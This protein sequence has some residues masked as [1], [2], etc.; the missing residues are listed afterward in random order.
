MGFG[1]NDNI[2]KKD[3]LFNDNRV[4]SRTKQEKKCI[5][6]KM[7]TFQR[8][9][10]FSY[11][12]MVI[13]YPIFYGSH[14]LN[15][16]LPCLSAIQWPSLKIDIVSQSKMRYLFIW[17]KRRYKSTSQCS[18]LCVFVPVWWEREKTWDW[19][20]IASAQPHNILYRLTSQPY[21]DNGTTCKKKCIS[22]RTRLI[23]CE[24]HSRPLQTHSVI[25]PCYA[26]FMAFHFF[27]LLRFFFSSQRWN[28]ISML[29]FALE[30][31]LSRWNIQYFI[32]KSDGNGSHLIQL[33]A[34][35]IQ[36]K[37]AYEKHG[38]R[39]GRIS[40]NRYIVCS[41]ENNTNN[42]CVIWPEHW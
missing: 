36:Y 3:V 40:D 32:V 27:L 22:S 4:K 30:I 7:I 25:V 8:Q 39:T 33:R 42:N 11:L 29:I 13:L 28:P 34:G 38:A 1:S 19:E 16:S 15:V 23:G 5:S 9:K 14:S 21:F 18:R 31:E 17:A 37:F 41:N 35:V 10:P 2:E 20:N 12:L 24:N 6:T 26:L